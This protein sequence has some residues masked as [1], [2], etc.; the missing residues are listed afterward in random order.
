MAAKND[1]RPRHNDILFEDTKIGFRNFAGNPDQF[2]PQ[3]G[4]RS[5]LVYLEEDAAQEMEKA[6]L[7]VKRTKEREDGSGNKPFIRVKVNMNGRPPRV[8]LITNQGK[9]Q[10]MLDED[11][12]E[13][14]D[15][16]EIEKVDVLVSPW[17]YDFNGSEGWT[18]YLQAIY[19]TIAE[20]YLTRK[21]GDIPIASVH[22]TQAE[23]FADDI[24]EAETS[25]DG[26]PARRGPRF[27]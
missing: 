3:G 27:E 25:E 11:M 8:V 13:M 20:D 5:F 18:F 15:Y 24:W 14:A 16:S 9:K 2:N 19:M 21:Y 6:N 22:E 1:Q 23:D 12:L 7:P 4:K 17:W 10:T 26:R